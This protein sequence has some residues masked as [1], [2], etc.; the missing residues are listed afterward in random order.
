LAFFRS[1][2]DNSCARTPRSQSVLVAGGGRRPD[3]QELERSVSI[4]RGW[5]L[6]RRAPI[7]FG[8]SPSQEMKV[9]PAE[10]ITRYR[11]VVFIDFWNFEGHLREQLG[12]NHAPLVWTE[13]SE[14]LVNAVERELSSYGRP[15]VCDLESTRVY[16]APKGT[17]YTDRWFKTRIASSPR[18]FMD[19]KKRQKSKAK[20][21]E[22][23]E[24]GHQCSHCGEPLIF[25]QEKGVDAALV[26]DLLWLAWQD[27][28]DVSIVV[29]SDS[30]L[31]AGI[32]RVQL[33]GKKVVN[34]RFTRVGDAVA[35]SS[36]A[37][38]DLDWLFEPRASTVWDVPGLHS[39]LFRD[40]V[41]EPAM[42]LLRGENPRALIAELKETD[43]YEALSTADHSHKRTLKSIA[44][45]EASAKKAGFPDPAA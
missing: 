25:D 10:P 8:M 32:E 2:A 39:H 43:W 35:Q 4:R 11:T 14:R 13:F 5:N 40:R 45:I 15:V 16:A 36:W 23:G 1:S 22:C 24:K 18:F 19:L 41:D 21:L 34:A 20:C 27:L 44:D 37:S 38:I 33:S 31:I 3:K 30:D 17:T 9:V 6:S 12:I 29:S 42:R 28:Y 26:T 7:L